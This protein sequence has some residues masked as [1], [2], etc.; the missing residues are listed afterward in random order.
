MLHGE[1]L[2]YRLL[3][4]DPN[5]T[6]IMYVGTGERMG[7]YTSEGSNWYSP[8][9]SKG[10]GIWKTTDGGA[11]WAQLPDCLYFSFV[12]DIVVRNESG[13]SVIYAGVGG[14]EFEGS[15]VGREFTGVWKSADGGVKLV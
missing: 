7:N 13:T 12:N 10:L 6:N 8:G 2:L 15:Y 11:T 3:R 9:V 1:V 14:N 5:D 4:T